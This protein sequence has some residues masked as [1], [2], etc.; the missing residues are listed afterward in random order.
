MLDS[1]IVCL[2]AL[3]IQL[4]EWANLKSQGIFN[5]IGLGVIYSISPYF[6]LTDIQQHG[7]LNCKGSWR[8]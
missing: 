3:S 6:P 2:C 1:S 8:K 7:H 4:E 5:V